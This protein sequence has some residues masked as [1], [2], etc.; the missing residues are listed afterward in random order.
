MNLKI[1]NTM[2]TLLLATLLNCGYSFAQD[3]TRPELVMNVGYYMTGNK[4][5][6]LMVHAKTKINKKF[7]PVS[8]AVINLYLDSVAIDHLVA[9]VTTNEKGV[10]KAVIPIALKSFWDNSATHRFA[11][12]SEANK[13]FDEATTDL[14]VTRSKIE[15]DTLRDGDT[16]NIKVTVSEFENN[17][18]TGVKDVDMRVGIRRLGGQLTA[19]KEETYT[20]DST[21]AV[22]VEFNKDSLPADQ[23][24][25][26]ILVAKVED[27]DKLGNLLVEKNVPWGIAANTDKNFFAQRTLWSTRF[28][29]PYW[30]LLMAYSLV[31]SIWST[32]IYLVIQLVKIKK[33]SAGL[34][35]ETKLLAPVQAS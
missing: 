4:L 29:T 33:L 7:Q 26:I 13:N 32:I 24:G 1:K 35:Q 14:S 10:A 9:R 16:K 11:A 3:S 19:G 27:N 23:Q 6:Y 20:T 30:L 5:I 25:N 8:G 18:W 2:G 12:V 31:I 28:R 21:G 17:K 34:P 22:T 15:I